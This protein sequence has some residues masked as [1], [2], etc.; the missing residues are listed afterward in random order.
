MSPNWFWPGSND[1][2][3]SPS[4]PEQVAERPDVDPRGWYCEVCVPECRIA[5]DDLI[6]HLRYQHPEIFERLF[7]LDDGRPLI[8]YDTQGEASS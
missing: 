6:D 3:W 8:F 1:Q 5:A 4:S 2:G 7:L